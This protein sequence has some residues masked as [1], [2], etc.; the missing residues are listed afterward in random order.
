MSLS[1]VCCMLSLVGCLSPVVCCLLFVA[2]RLLFVRCLL[3]VVRCS[4]WFVVACNWVDYYCC[5]CVPFAVGCDCLLL[6]KSRVAVLLVVAC[7]KVCVAG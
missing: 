2:R 4:L 5:R 3:R 1:I 6:C 7:L